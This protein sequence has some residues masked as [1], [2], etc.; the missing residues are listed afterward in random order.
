M[1]NLAK[2]KFCAV[3]QSRV[4]QKRISPKVIDRRATKTNIIR[5]CNYSENLLK[6]RYINARIVISYILIY[7]TVFLD[8]HFNAK[9]RKAWKFKRRSVTKRTPLLNLNFV[10]RQFLEGFYFDPT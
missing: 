4:I 6:F 8:H 3:F 5:F 9:R 10:E 1:N 7:V 2:I